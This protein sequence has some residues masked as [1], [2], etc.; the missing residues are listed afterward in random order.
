[1]TFHHEVIQIGRPMALTQQGVLTQTILS[2]VTLKTTMAAITK[3]LP[4]GWVPAIALLE[5]PTNIYNFLEISAVALENGRE[6]Q[7]QIAL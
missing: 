3:H 5:T 6:V 2:P 4:G 1:M 7:A